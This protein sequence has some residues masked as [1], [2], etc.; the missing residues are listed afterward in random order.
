MRD[1][2]RHGILQ[3]S[4]MDFFF[5]SECKKLYYCK[6]DYDTKK[7]GLLACLVGNQTRGSRV[8]LTDIYEGW[9]WSATRGN[10]A[11][12]TITSLKRK[13][14]IDIKKRHRDYALGPRG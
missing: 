10:Q 6:I 9:D 13:S 8:A 1:N 14:N 2:G 12:P 7:G 4:F 3:F 5:V 11:S